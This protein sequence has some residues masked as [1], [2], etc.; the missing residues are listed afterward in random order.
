MPPRKRARPR[1][2]TLLPSYSQLEQRLTLLSW[3]HS[4]LGYADTKQLLDDTR[5]A[6]EGFDGDGRSHIY[7]RLT[8]RNDPEIPTE[9]LRRY[10]DNIRE[11]LAAMN[12]GRTQPITLR[13]FQYLAAFYTEL[14]LDRYSTSPAALLASLNKHVARLNSNRRG[15]RSVERYE[16]TDL[17]KLAFC[18]VVP[19]KRTGC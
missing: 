15:S 3:L 19:E 14:L 18:E 7:R 11:H 8:E 9:D 1:Q 13:Y 17:K 5:P 4:L 2:N 16:A 6:K 10:D 12:R